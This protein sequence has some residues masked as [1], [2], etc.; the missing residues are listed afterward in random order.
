MSIR[1]LPPSIA[2]RLTSVDDALAMI[3]GSIGDLMDMTVDQVNFGP[4]DLWILDKNIVTMKTY[5][6]RAEQLIREEKK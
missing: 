2:T 6:D 3:D 1:P 4:K 5:Y